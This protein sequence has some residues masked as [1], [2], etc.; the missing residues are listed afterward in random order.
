MRARSF[1]IAILLPLFLYLS[2]YTWNWRTG[3]LDR[4]ATNTGMEFVGWVLVPGEWVHARL[5]HY[6]NS[7]INLLE[8]RQ[9]NRYLRQRLEELQLTRMKLERQAAEARRLK[10]LLKFSSPEGWS[11]FGAKV[12]AHKMGPHAVAETIFVDKGSTDEVRKDMPVLTPEGI[13]GRVYRV[14]NSFASVLLL[15]DPNSRIPVLGRK[16]RTNGILKGQGPDSALEVMYVPQNAALYDHELLVTSG[17]SD[18]F[19]KGLPVARIQSI[20]HSETSLFQNVQAEPLV[21]IR[22]LEEVLLI[23]KPRSPIKAEEKLKRP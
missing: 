22:F 7:Y 6:W 15:T 23:K 9:E 11:Q 21:T 5:R 18:I 3:H 8:V 14:S 4:L 17:L 19:P 16:S 1:V 12:I 13:I 10:R 20:T 2:L